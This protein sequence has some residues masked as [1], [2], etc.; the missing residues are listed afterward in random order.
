MGYTTTLNDLLGASGLASMVAGCSKESGDSVDVS[1]VGD[2]ATDY[3]FTV[4]GVGDSVFNME[5]TIG[6]YPV[7]ITVAKMTP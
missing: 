6:T 5:T 1:P 7:T 4:V 2:P 3:E